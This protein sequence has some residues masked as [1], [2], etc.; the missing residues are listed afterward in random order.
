ME[1]N[2]TA[3]LEVPEVEVHSTARVWPVEDVRRF[4]ESTRETLLGPLWWVMAVS[5][6]DAGK[7]WGSLGMTC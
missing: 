2:P 1:R 6:I 3:R 7:R 5:G 4:L